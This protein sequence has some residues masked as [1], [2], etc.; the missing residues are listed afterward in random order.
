MKL[1]KIILR[2]I[3][4]FLGIFVIK[5]VFA[6]LLIIGSWSLS[7]SSADLIAG[8]GSDINNHFVSISNQV[9]IDITDVYTIENNWRI[10]VHKTDVIWDTNIQLF[11]ARTGEGSG[12]KKS[13]IL[14]GLTYQNITDVEQLFFAGTG[15]RIGVP[16]QLKLEGLT[17]RLPLGS[18]ATTVVYT[19]TE[20]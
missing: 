18:Y 14:G 13:K 1:K 10:D 19:I 4:L 12:E 9:M 20:F 11:I 17:I 16:I 8:A 15:Q 7:I 5:T 3:L 2:S 6:G